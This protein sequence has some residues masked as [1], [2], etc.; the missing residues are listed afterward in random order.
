MATALHHELRSQGYRVE[1]DHAGIQPLWRRLDHF[2]SNPRSDPIVLDASDY[3]DRLPHTSM[4]PAD[5][6]GTK[7]PQLDHLCK[8]M[9]YAIWTKKLA[10]R[11]MPDPENVV[12][13]LDREVISKAQRALRDQLGEWPGRRPLVF[14]ARLSSIK[15]RS[16][17][18][19]VLRRVLAEI[20]ADTIPCQLLGDPGDLCIE[21][22]RH[23]WFSDPRIAAGACLSATALLTADTFILHLANGRIHAVE[24]LGM[25]DDV[26][27]SRQGVILTCGS[28]NPAVTAYAGNK[29]GG[30]LRGGLSHRALRRPRV[31]RHRAIREALSPRIL[32]VRRRQIR[33]HLLQLPSFGRVAMHGG[34]RAR[35]GRAGDSQRPANCARVA[36]ATPSAK[37]DS[38]D[39][40]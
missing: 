12:T 22:A 28:S 25:A 35:G 13:P 31:C 33:V 23:L 36:A 20:A 30:V 8:W 10:F 26:A 24:R 4:L 21:G 2:E 32:P 1:I 6:S 34:S 27:L 11:L 19:A 3:L 38:H 7:R 39:L 29:V 37:R 40:P 16:L 5:F 15:N 9:A 14:F 17:A 18:P